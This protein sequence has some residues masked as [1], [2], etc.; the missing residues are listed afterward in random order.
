VVEPNSNAA[1]PSLVVYMPFV[2]K[3]YYF[4]LIKKE[5]ENLLS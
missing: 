4:L 1:A 5:E 3:I 2:L